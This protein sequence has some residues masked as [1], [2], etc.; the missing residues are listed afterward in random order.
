MKLKRRICRQC[1]LKVL[2]LSLLIKTPNLCTE[3]LNTSVVF[4]LLLPLVNT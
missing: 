3:L 2:D 1:V 4:Q